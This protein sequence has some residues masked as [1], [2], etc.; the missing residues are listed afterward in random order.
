MAGWPKCPWCGSFNVKYTRDGGSLLCEEKGCIGSRGHFHCCS[1]NNS[2]A[3]RAPD[4]KWYFFGA[5]PLTCEYHGVG[6]AKAQAKAAAAADKCPWCGTGDVITAY[7]GGSK[8]CRAP[9]CRAPMRFHLCESRNPAAVKA[10][11]G[12]FYGVL[13][14]GTACCQYCQQRKQAPSRNA[15]PDEEHGSFIGGCPWCGDRFRVF[16]NDGGSPVCSRPGCPGTAGMHKC[17]KNNPDAKRAPDGQWYHLGCGKLGCP[18]DPQKD[19]PRLNVLSAQP[20]KD[21]WASPFM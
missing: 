19:K 16:F 21:A 1:Q 4:G 17:C 20:L 15:P 11:D 8:T 9:G 5:S 13:T 7:D 14:P 3:V 6:M 10:P 2:S 18:Y 12:R